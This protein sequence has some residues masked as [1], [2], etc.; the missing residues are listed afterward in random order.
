MKGILKA[1]APKLVSVVASSNPVAGTVLKMATKKLGLPDNSTPE[2]IE[3]EIERNPEKA[4]LIS[5]VELQVKQMDIELET[6]KTQVADVQDARSKFGKDPTPKILAVLAML[7][8]LAYIFMVT[9]QAPENNDD[10]IVNL[11]LGYLG[12]LVTGISSFYFGSS[13][14]GNS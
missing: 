7:G 12:G 8:F 14:N 9:L 3:E 5:D 13:H 6:F 4:S 1:L 10:A 11:V 2:Q